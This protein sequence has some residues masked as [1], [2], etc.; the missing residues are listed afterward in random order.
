[1]R[2]RASIAPA[3]PAL[4][5][6]CVLF[7]VLL[8]APARADRIEEQIDRLEE[9][10]RQALIDGNRNELENILDEDFFY[11]TAIGT[12]VSRASLIRDITS[13]T[14][15]IR[16]VTRE[17]ALI[18]MYGD[19]ALVS[20]LTR[21]VAVIQGQEQTVLSRHLHVWVHRGQHW[22]LAARQ[23]TPVTERK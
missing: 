1:M 17:P 11:N 23:V 13:G 16:Q 5:W 21:A 3:L 15:K 14:V 12:R 18:Q 19:V 8:S 2:F 6:A 9:Q 7:C 10:W 20:G 22:K 4:C